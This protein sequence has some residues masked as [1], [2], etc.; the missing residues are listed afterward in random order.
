MTLYYLLKCVWVL[1]SPSDINHSTWKIGSSVVIVSNWKI[2][3][4]QFCHAATK[5][6]EHREI[7][8]SGCK[9]LC[10]AGNTFRDFK[11][12][13]GLFA[14]KPEPVCGNWDSGLIFETG[15]FIPSLILGMSYYI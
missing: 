8:E 11:V 9:E 10:D 6:H 5:V 15:S 7:K 3:N 1:E 2:G 13:M 4:W 14:L 12:K